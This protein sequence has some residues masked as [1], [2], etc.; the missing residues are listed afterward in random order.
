MPA[1]THAKLAEV[2][3]RL[4]RPVKL[5]WRSRCD[6]IYGMF[7]FVGRPNFGALDELHQARQEVDHFSNNIGI[8]DFD[9]ANMNST[10]DPELW[11]SRIVLEVKTQVQSFH[12]GP[13]DD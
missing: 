3:G 9:G 13:D 7:C 12:W 10:A 11:L 4:P 6:F 2:A 5:T 1:V 8:A